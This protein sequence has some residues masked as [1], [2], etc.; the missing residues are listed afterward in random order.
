MS[1]SIKQIEEEIR[2]LEREAQEV[3]AEALHGHYNDEE[4][5]KQR[6]IEAEKVS[7]EITER[8]IEL[9]RK[10]LE[11]IRGAREFIDYVR[12]NDLDCTF[13]VKYP[14]ELE[15]KLVEAVKLFLNVPLKYRKF[16]LSESLIGLTASVGKDMQEYEEWL[17]RVYKPLKKLTYSSK[18]DL[19]D[20]EKAKLLDMLLE[21]TGIDA[22]TLKKLM[23][24]R[25]GDVML[26]VNTMVGVESEDKIREWLRSN[27]GGVRT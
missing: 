27:L 8:V 16:V 11:L 13:I 10:K 2:R 24:G 20:R 17:E 25:K 23:T 9:K 12:K 21:D 26:M 14:D 4:E 19:S 5:H 18:I 22:F 1:T 3:L 7:S 15:D 6:I